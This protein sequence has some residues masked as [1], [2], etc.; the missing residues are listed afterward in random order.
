MFCP[1]CACEYVGWTECPSCRIPLVEELPPSL[2]TA[3]KSISYEALV[4]LVRE[5]GGQLETDLSTTDVG[6][7]SI[8]LSVSWIQVCMGK[9][10]PRRH[11]QQSC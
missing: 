10:D 7:E 11:S 2:E 5:N 9:E 3:D 6:I 8:G 4:D 1:G